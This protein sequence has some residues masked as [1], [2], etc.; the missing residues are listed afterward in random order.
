MELG[1]VEKVRLI[2]KGSLTGGRGHSGGR[3]G[4]EGA[5]WP[6]GGLGPVKGLLTGASEA[7]AVGAAPVSEH[8]LEILVAGG[9]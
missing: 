6:V 8:N 7:G 9:K 1:D 2:S 5:K 4:E 3:K